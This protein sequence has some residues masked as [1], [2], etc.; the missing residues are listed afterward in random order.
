MTSTLTPEAFRAD[1]ADQET[2]EV[3]L[4]LKTH[5]FDEKIFRTYESGLVLV[6][7]GIN[8]AVMGGPDFNPADYGIAP[9]ARPI[10]NF[11]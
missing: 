10:P 8:P 9:A 7:L 2:V 3:G 5:H 1:L 4:K 11:L 6:S